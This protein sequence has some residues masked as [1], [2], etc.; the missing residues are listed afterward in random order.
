MF[1]RIQIEP[2]NQRNRVYINDKLHQS[3]DLDMDAFIYST[4]NLELHEHLTEDLKTLLW[5]C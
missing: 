3:K 4:A 2:D 5:E 1:F